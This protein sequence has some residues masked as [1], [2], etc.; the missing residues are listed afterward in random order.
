[1]VVAAAPGCSSTSDAPEVAAGPDGVV[2]PTLVTGRSVWVARCASCHGAD[3]GGG[4][5]PRL[6]DGR[7]VERYPDLTDAAAFVAVGRGGMPAFGDD[8]DD[9]ELAAV[10]RYVAEV[11]GG[12]AAAP[13]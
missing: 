12:S 3:G 9:T 4:S 8:L 7:L 13:G 6:N 2:D 11:L 5:G 1:M 10:V